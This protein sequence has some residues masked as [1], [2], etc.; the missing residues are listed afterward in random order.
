MLQN[1]L[2][3]RY[4]ECTSQNTRF[5]LHQ[6]PSRQDCFIQLQRSSATSCCSMAKLYTLALEDAQCFEFL[7]THSTEPGLPG[8]PRQNNCYPPNAQFQRFSTSKE[9]LGPANP[10]AAALTVNATW[11]WSVTFAHSDAIRRRS[12]KTRKEIV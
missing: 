3:N 9:S 12:S 10:F 8:N 11:S 4:R 5:R 1:Y 2:Q 6:Q 7:R